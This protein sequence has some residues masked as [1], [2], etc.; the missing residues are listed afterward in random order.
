MSSIFLHKVAHDLRSPISVIA[1]YVAERRRGSLSVDE[2]QQYLMA[3]QTSIE[4]LTRIA[5]AVAERAGEL[6]PS[7][8]SNPAASENR[9]PTDINIDT[10]KQCV[11]IVDDNEGIRL[12]WRHIFKSKPYTILE[13]C[14]GEHLLSM[15]IDFT[16]IRAAIVDYQY[17]GSD[18][19]GLDVIEYLKRKKIPHIHLCTANHGDARL[20]E[21][22]QHLGVSS[23]IPKPIPLSGL[24]ELVE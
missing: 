15:K 5:D 3:I 16:S 1:G 11:L 24:G 19:N 20:C 23:I 10:N 12:Q 7:P 22:A 13:A 2:D 18:L 14:S 17:E 21:K 9:S 8:S 4:R 6:L